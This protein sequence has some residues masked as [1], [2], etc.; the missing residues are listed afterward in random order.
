MYLSRY[1][2]KRNNIKV[3]NNNNAQLLFHSSINKLINRSCL[4]KCYIKNYCEKEN[5]HIIE[6]RS[7]SFIQR[8]RH[9]EWSNNVVSGIQEKSAQAWGRSWLAE[10]LVGEE[11]PSFCWWVRGQMASQLASSGMAFQQTS[12]SQLCRRMGKPWLVSHWSRQV[13]C[14][15]QCAQCILSQV[16]GSK[17]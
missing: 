1:C 3:W 4:M 11:Q 10:R 16:L 5:Q 14:C 2:T 8:V 7:A 12:G 17:L 13:S 15:S 9:E 6:A